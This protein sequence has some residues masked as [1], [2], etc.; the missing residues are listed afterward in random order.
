PTA[1]LRRRTRRPSSSSHC[2]GERSEVFQA[3]TTWTDHNVPMWRH[4]SGPP[5]LS[6]KN[7]RPAPGGNLH[8]RGSWD[9]RSGA[10]LAAPGRRRRGRGGG[11][12]RPGDLGHSRERTFMIVGLASPGIATSIEDGLDRMKRLLAE[13]AAQGAQIVCFPEA[14]LPGLRGQDFEV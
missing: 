6:D 2:G 10:G 13:A 8:E 14:Y 11:A 4:S 5:L 7:W 12:G 1:S 3:R 9:R